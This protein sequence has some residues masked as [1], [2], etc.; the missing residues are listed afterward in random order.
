M[1]KN[2]I[3]YSAGKKVSLLKARADKRIVKRIGINELADIIREAKFTKEIGKLRAYYPLLPLNHLNGKEL[4]NSDIAKNIPEVC[5]SKLIKFDNGT[6]KF[7]AYTGMTLLE[8]KNMREYNDAEQLR[9]MASEMPQTVM[10]F[11]GAD[12][13]SVEIVCSSVPT[14][15]ELPQEMDKANLF[16]LKAYRKAYLAYSAQ[17]GINIDNLEPKLDRTCLVSADSNVFYQENAVPFYI[18]DEDDW[19]TISKYK[20]LNNKDIDDSC[21]MPG[22]NITETRRY[23]YQCCLNKAF[24]ES[25]LETG[26]D[27]VTK[28]L[29][30]LSH[31]C[32]ESGLPIEMAIKHTLFRQDIGSDENYVRTVF[33]NAYIKKLLKEVPLKHVPDSALLTFKTEAMLKSTYEMR[34]NVITG[35]VQFR[36]RDGFNYE[37]R[38]LTKMDRNDMALASLKTGNNS[39]DKDLNRILESSMPPEY[40]P[41]ADYLNHLPRWDGKDRITEMAERVPTDNQDWIKNFHVWMMS[42]VAQWQGKNSSRGNAIVPLLIGYQGSGKSTFCS[43][44]LPPDLFEYYNDKLSFDNDNAV[45]LALSRFALINLD[46]FDSLKKS[47][48]PLLKY[49]VQ[50]NDVKLRKLYSQSIVS[51]RRYA[52][53]IGTTNSS[54]PLTD[55][56]GSRRFVC[57]KVT[58]PI[59]FITPINYSQFYSQVVEEINNGSRYW[60]NEDDN[61]RIQEHNMRFTQPTSISIMLSSI[62]AKP[63]N[64]NDGQFMYLSDVA[65]TISDKYK[66]FD[67]SSGALVK[68][69]RYLSQQD[70]ECKRKTAGMAYRV[71][72]L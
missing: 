25:R 30:L 19:K 1:K 44:I 55:E 61:I 8:V 20:S 32:H 41:I 50:K 33:A 27:Y 52:S 26:N 47:Q 49:L 24:E 15:G 65:N 11:I 3:N 64:E 72:M 70:F 29:T 57:A 54:M 39:W 23:V 51:Q 56:T 14:N 7:D 9:T 21:L 31:Y 22:Y 40:D 12:G 71:K 37:F 18:N 17:L 46:E 60:F 53:F 35:E 10:A 59:D 16:N 6:D 58:G 36:R 63:K 69:G 68:I 38:T 45:M 42:M 28:V 34:R 5:F 48:Q 13:H 4:R 67:T 66:N 62:L 2:T 43:N